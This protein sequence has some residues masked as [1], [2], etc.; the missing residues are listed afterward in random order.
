[1]TTPT[2]NGQVL[3]SAE[4]AVRALLARRLDGTGLDYYRWVALNVTATVTAGDGPTAE[5][6][7]IVALMADGLKI[8]DDAARAHLAALADLGLVESSGGRIALTPAGTAR[9][10]ALRAGIAELTR[11]LYG[12][13]TPEDLAVT[14]RVLTTLTER[15]NALLAAA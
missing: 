6:E 15:A 1:M 5:I 3:G 12:D 9:H 4:N 8:S 2:L 10:Q 13:F 7:R 14:G 11:T